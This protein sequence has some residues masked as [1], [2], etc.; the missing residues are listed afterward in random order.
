MVYQTIAVVASEL[1][2]YVRSLSMD[3][4]VHYPGVRDKRIMSAWLILG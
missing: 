2:V 1:I 3:Y 4:D